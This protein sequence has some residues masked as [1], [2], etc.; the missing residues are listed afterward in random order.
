MGDEKFMDAELE[1][2]N[3]VSLAQ[4]KLSK[5]SLWGGQLRLNCLPASMLI[6][7]EAKKVWPD[8]HVVIGHIRFSGRPGMTPNDKTRLLAYIAEPVEGTEFHAW[9]KLDRG[10][11][12]DVVAPTFAPGGSTTA[13]RRYVDQEAATQDGIEY[14]VVISEKHQVEQFYHKLTSLRR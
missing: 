8:A 3:L 10:D 2:F 5:S 9:I 7:D 1:K 13:E 12:L 11:F 6:L 4:A 14:T